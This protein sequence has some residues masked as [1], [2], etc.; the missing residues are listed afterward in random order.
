MYYED[1]IEEVQKTNDIL[2]NST[3]AHVEALVSKTSDIMI[4]METMNNSFTI[5]I[6]LLFVL[7]LRDIF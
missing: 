5:M 6:I 7:V 2:V 3:N 1:L 4:S